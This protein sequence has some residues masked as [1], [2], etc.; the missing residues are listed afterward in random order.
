M[1]YDYIIVGAGAAGCVL[2]NRLSE[3]PQTRVLL[4]EAGGS[5]DRFLIRMPLGMLRAFRDPTLTWGFMSEPEPHLNGRVFAVTRGRVLGG[6]S[7]INGMF[8][9]RGHSTDFDGWQAQGARAG[10]TRT[11]CRI[12]RSWNRAGAG[13]CPITAP[14]VPCRSRPIATT[15]L[16]HEPLMPTAAP[17]GYWT[18]DDLHGRLEEGFARGEITVDARGRRASAARAY[19]KPALHRPNLEVMQGALTTRVLVETGRARGHR[20]ASRQRDAQRIRRTA[21]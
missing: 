10:A 5:D 20:A 4:V 9:M 15:K 7:S 18:S 13:R 12:S 21:K 16:L 14:A 11:C 3:D 19:L 17:A 8:F 6:S 1:N 2:A